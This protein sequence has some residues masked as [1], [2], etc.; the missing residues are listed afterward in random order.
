MQTRGPSSDTSG[1]ELASQGS[2]VSTE[3]AT[4]AIAMLQKMRNKE[5]RKIPPPRNVGRSTSADPQRNQRVEGDSPG[6]M[7]GL[8]PAVRACMP[9]ME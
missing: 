1:K 2:S 8:P 6:C 7:G 3:Q 5:E 4:L 9:S